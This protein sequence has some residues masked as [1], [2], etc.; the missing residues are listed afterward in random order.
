M[1]LAVKR[2]LV[3]QPKARQVEV[4]CSRCRTL[5]GKFVM[6]KGEMMCPKSNCKTMNKLDLVSQ[7]YLLTEDAK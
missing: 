6:G 1:S 5:L 4:R 2:V 7:Q 3:V